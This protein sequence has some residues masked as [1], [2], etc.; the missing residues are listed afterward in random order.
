M[1]EICDLYLLD[2]V[3]GSSSLLQRLHIFDPAARFDRSQTYVGYLGLNLKR[4]TVVAILTH[5]RTNGVRGLN[6]PVR[7][8][9]DL[10]PAEE[11]R[12]YADI[13]MEERGGRVMGP[14]RSVNPMLW[15]FQVHDPAESSLEPR[16]GGGNMTVD[17]LDGHIWTADES[18]EYGYDYNNLL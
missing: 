11:A 18:I 4:I 16:E 5:F 17:A 7:Y 10:M 14:R 9:T 3:P 12:L 6:I 2:A 13:H 15:H 8:R 1:Q